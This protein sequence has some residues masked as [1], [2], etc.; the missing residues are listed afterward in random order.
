M[1]KKIRCD[2]GSC[3]KFQ[4]TE[5]EQKW[6]HIN[7]DKRVHDEHFFMENKEMSE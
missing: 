1:Y 3:E 7:L 2:V 6:E 4:C 5:L